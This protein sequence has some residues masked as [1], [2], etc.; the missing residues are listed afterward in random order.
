MSESDN[1]DPDD[2]DSHDEDQ[3]WNEESLKNY[4]LNVLNLLKFSYST[5][6]EILSAL[7]TDIIYQVFNEY[8]KDSHNTDFES[9]KTVFTAEKLI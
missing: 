8:D 7:L 5:S 6:S 4:V 2:H 9:W 3:L 1:T